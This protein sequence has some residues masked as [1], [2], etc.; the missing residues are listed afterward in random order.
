LPSVDVVVDALLVARQRVRAVFPQRGVE[1]GIG[2]QLGALLSLDR[3]ER[4]LA[5]A[6]LDGDRPALAH[7]HP[8]LPQG[9][10]AGLPEG[11]VPGLVAFAPSAG[12]ALAVEALAVA[13][14]EVFLV[15]VPRLDRDV[16]LLAIGVELQL[17]L[18]RREVERGLGAFGGD[19]GSFWFRQRRGRKQESAREE[20]EDSARHGG[21]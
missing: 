6:A 12:R 5:I 16:V 8:A 18:H 4:G 7:A 17:L 15:R 3:L 9:S 2:Q 13:I 1:G 10:H 20:E 11:A 21:V 14:I 19:R